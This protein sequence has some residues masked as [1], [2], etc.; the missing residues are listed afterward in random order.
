MLVNYCPNWIFDLTSCAIAREFL[1]SPLGLDSISQKFQAVFKGTYQ[2]IDMTEL[3]SAAE[4]VVFMLNEADAGENSVEILEGFYYFRSRFEMDKTPR[5]T[6]GL[7][8]SSLKGDKNCRY[9]NADTRKKF[10]AYLFG[11]RNNAVPLPPPTWSI[12]DDDIVPL[13]TGKI[14]QTPSILDSI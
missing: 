9:N 8:A 7:F 2:E 11:L 10:K 3:S 4:N 14:S 12:E 6:T 5:K 13:L 1:Q